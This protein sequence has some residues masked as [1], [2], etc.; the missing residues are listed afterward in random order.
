[1]T[2]QYS[3]GTRGKSETL[4]TKSD[5]HTNLRGWQTVEQKYPAQNI[6][7][8]FY[9]ERKYDTREDEEG[10]CYDWYVISGHYRVVDNTPLLQQESDKTNANLDYIAMMADIDLP[11]EDKNGTLEE[12]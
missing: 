1:M 10:N 6:T 2:T 7:D 12:V 3:Y 5:A 8:R 9:V 11:E 4:R